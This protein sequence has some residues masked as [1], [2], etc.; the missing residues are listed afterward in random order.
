MQ[1]HDAAG[2]QAADAVDHCLEV[3]C[4]GRGIEVRIFVYREARP[5]EQCDVVLPGR[6]TDPDF[7]AGEVVLE[8][9]RTDLQRART[10]NGLHSGNAAS[11]QQRAGFSEKQLLHVGS[12]A[13]QTFHWQVQGCVGRLLGEL[14]LERYNTLGYRNHTVFVVVETDAEVHFVPAVILQIL[15]HQGKNRI[16]RVLFNVLVHADPLA[17]IQI[18]GDAMGARR[19]ITED[20]LNWPQRESVHGLASSC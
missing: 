11:L 18:G 8:E 1:Q 14:R 4:T 5:R 10:T 3:H 7:G 16:A 13:G 15:F 19:V 12:V 6:V 9:V 20:R 17:G 2:W